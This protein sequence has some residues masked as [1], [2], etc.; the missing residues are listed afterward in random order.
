MRDALTAAEE[1]RDYVPAGT[2]DE[3]NEA[4]LPNGIGTPLADASA[5]S[6]HLLG[7]I[8]E[9]RAKLGDRHLKWFTAPSADDAVLRNSY[10]HPRRHLCEYMAEN[11]DT[12]RARKLL[13]DSLRELGEVSAPEYVTS[14]L[15]AL[16]DDPR[17]QTEVKS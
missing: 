17:F 12:E 7:E 2:V 6:D 10:A 9:L 4:E 11:G 8:I 13:D 16:R 14:T 1:G 3:I 5:R 15:V